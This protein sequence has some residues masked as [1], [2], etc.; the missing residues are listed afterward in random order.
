V[1]KIEYEY[2]MYEY[3]RRVREYIVSRPIPAIYNVSPMVT[4]RTNIEEHAEFCQFLANL[5]NELFTGDQTLLYGSEILKGIMNA[6][7]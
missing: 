5:Y 7:K 6:S 4:Q 3:N 2:A 1:D